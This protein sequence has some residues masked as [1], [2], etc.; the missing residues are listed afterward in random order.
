MMVSCKYRWAK[1]LSKRKSFPQESIPYFTPISNTKSFNQKV[2]LDNLRPGAPASNRLSLS[3]PVIPLTATTKPLFTIPD[4]SWLV[5]T[6]RAPPSPSL[7]YCKQSL[8]IFCAAITT[9]LFKVYV[10]A[11]SRKHQNRKRK[12]VCLSSSP[13]APLLYTIS[14]RSAPPAQQK[15]NPRYSK[16]T[17]ST[18][19]NLKSSVT[20]DSPVPSVIPQLS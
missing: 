11:M 19:I 9:S 3:S 17:P 6:P 8:T 15:K 10:S 2:V 13:A 7:L 20:S 18:Y 16:S 14:K 12:I 4:G 5:P 1:I